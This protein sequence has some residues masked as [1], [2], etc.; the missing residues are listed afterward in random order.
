MDAN[1]AG[2]QVLI[3]LR[4]G[5]NDVRATAFTWYASSSCVWPSSEVLRVRH[6]N[7]AGNASQIGRYRNSQ[8]PLYWL[9]TEHWQ[10][11][12]LRFCG[13]VGIG[14]DTNIMRKVVNG[15]Y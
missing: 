13:V 8:V 12:H 14:Q 5:A 4:P 3:N 9:G 1:H 10:P 6:G 2:L 11:V 7:V 15:Q